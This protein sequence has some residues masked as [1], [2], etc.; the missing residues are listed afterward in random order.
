MKKTFGEGSSKVEALR[1]IDLEVAEGE[2]LILMGPSGSGKTTLI[3]IISGILSQTEGECKLGDVDI[4]HLPD[5]EK[6]HFRGKHIGFVFQTF[7]LIPMLTCK[8]NIA[9]P[10]LL[11]NVDRNQAE[12][13]ATKVLQD[14]GIGE[15]T[16]ITPD[17]ISGGQ[18]QRV[19]IARG[20]IHTPE[21]IVCDEPTSQLDHETGIKIVELLRS[22][23]K[24]RNTTLIVV[25]HDN[26]IMK[27]ADRIAKLE[28]GRIVNGTPA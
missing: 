19:A 24:E 25:T 26:R 3:S 4:N 14:V 7:N 2:F 10:L 27:Y 15:K 21:L 17:R 18:Q 1:G 5:K 22:I 6:I 23:V 16:D 11:N 13:R 20:V 8:E 12:D 9:I 28:D